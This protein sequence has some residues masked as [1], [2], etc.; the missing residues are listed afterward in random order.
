LNQE[1]LRKE[2]STTFPELNFYRNTS[3]RSKNR[4]NPEEI[5]I[6]SENFGLE[7]QK[8]TLG[9]APSQQNLQTHWLQGYQP[10]YLITWYQLNG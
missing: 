5:T 3:P 6:V 8:K 4:R 2:E 10:N 9:T 7:M 1:K